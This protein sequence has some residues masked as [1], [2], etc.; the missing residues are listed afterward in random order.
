MDFPGS[1]YYSDSDNDSFEIREHIAEYAHQ[2]L[3]DQI[4]ED[5]Y[6]KSEMAARIRIGLYDIICIV[7]YLYNMVLGDLNVAIK[8]RLVNKRFKT[9][10]D[11]KFRYIRNIS[12]TI[13]QPLFGDQGVI[14]AVRPT[15]L[16]NCLTVHFDKWVLIAF[17]N[18]HLS[19]YSRQTR[20]FYGDSFYNPFNPHYRHFV[21]RER[22]WI[23]AA[24]GHDRSDRDSVLVTHWTNWFE[25]ATPL[26]KD[27][28][29]VTS[30]TCI[31]TQVGDKSVFTPYDED[32]PIITAKGVWYGGAVKMLPRFGR[33]SAIIH[34][35]SSVWRRLV[36]GRMIFGDEP[37]ANEGLSLHLMELADIGIAA[38][39]LLSSFESQNGD[40]C[41]YRNRWDMRQF[42]R[43]ENN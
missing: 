5:E 10:L 14:S 43:V 28:I 23:N 20:L 27:L 4:F 22:V 40:L 39:H 35:L 37:N 29:V 36:E 9:L 21:D 24:N 18:T 2:S 42:K 19:K 8:M 33:T 13:S 25:E 32:A 38:L 3:E 34:L 26:P 7:T 1:D 31:Y 41:T 12:E 30:A 17:T 15:I 16:T 11:T 6:F